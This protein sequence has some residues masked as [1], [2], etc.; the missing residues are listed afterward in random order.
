MADSFT[1]NYNLTKPEIGASRD[2]WGGKTNSNWDTIDGLLAATTPIGVLLDFA[3]VTAPTGWLLADGGWYLNTQYPGLYAVVGTRFGG[4]ASHFAVPDTRA[5]AIVGV[6][7]ST[8]GYGQTFNYAIAQ[9]GGN[10]GAVI[11][12]AHLPNY[13]LPETADGA[14]QH[15]Y[16]YADEQGW[17]AH[18]GA[19]AGAGNHNHIFT[20]PQLGGGWYIAG[21]GGTQIGNQD[22]YTTGVGDHAHYFTTDGAGSGALLQIVTM[23]LAV[24]KIIYAGPPASGTLQ[25]LTAP[26]TQQLLAAPMRGQN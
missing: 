1:G 5:R 6:G 3:G 20:A 4:D 10:N 19:T 7:A 9:R 13:Q 8:D 11:G 16:G 17:H 22:R 12:R 26:L 23:Y 15:P 2:S 25:Q 14:H 21:G 24:T 18:T